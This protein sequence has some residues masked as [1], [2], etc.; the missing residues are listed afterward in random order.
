M[1][2]ILA[3]AQVVLLE[4]VRRKDLY[5]LLIV[6]V[7]LTLL[8]AT[9]NVFNQARLV[10]YVKEICLLMIWVSSLVIAVMTSARQVPA[11]RENRTLFPL[12]AKPV[13]RTQFLL[14]KFAGC[15]LACGLA[16]IGFYLVFVL[17]MLTRETNPPLL[18]YFQA[19]VLHWIGLGVICALVLLGSLLFPAIPANATI[20]FFIVGGIMLFARYLKDF[21]VQLSEPFQTTL[22]LVFY[23]MPHLEMFDIRD[24]IV[25]AWPLIPWGIWSVAIVYGL[26]F[27][28]L[29]LVIGC[30]LFRRKAV[31]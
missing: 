7:V 23:C 8:V 5:V 21:S 12:L 26:F 4:M 31:N 28:A 25:H 30:C 27:T 3:I 2:K 18:S 15:W 20:S 14:G 9:V 11:E 29:F 1:R 24:R 16:L 10:R 17:L 22:M 6:T 19:M 13:S